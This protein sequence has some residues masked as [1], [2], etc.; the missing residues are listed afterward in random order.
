MLRY[1]PNKVF[2]L[3]LVSAI[4]IGTGWFFVIKNNNAGKTTQKQSQYNQNKTAQEDLQKDSDGDGLKD[5]EEIL[6]KTDPRNPDSDR[7]GLNDNEEAIAQLN[8]YPRPQELN[9][10]NDTVADTNENLTQQVAENFGAAYLTRK[11]AAISNPGSLKTPSLEGLEALAFSD[12][13]EAIEH[14]AV[15]EIPDKFT[16]ADIQTY[17]DTS[18]L[19]VRTYINAVGEIIAKAPNTPQKSEV[20]ILEEVIMQEN[21]TALKEIKLHSDNYRYFAEKIKDIRVPNL[22]I[23]SHV[24]LMNTF[25]RLHVITNNMA[26][27]DVDPLKSLASI[28]QYDQEI[29]NSLE[30]LGIIVDEMKKHDITFSDEEGGMIFNKYVALRQ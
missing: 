21:L 14:T 22:F 6:W 27:M 18:S 13:K 5:W 19:A 30:P 11:L 2:V 12:M 8:S 3:V 20:E 25:W 24:V 29:K 4:V 26:A 16:V 23:D 9:K 1:L 17:A 7:D 10:Q 28:S 15:A